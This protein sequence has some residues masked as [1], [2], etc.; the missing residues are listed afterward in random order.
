MIFI[1][2]RKGTEASLFNERKKIERAHEKFLDVT[3]MKLI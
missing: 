2:K 1:S 3:M